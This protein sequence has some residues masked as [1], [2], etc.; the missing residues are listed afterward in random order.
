[1][2]QLVVAVCDRD[3][4]YGRKLSEYWMQ[5]QELSEVRY[6]GQEEELDSCL[7][8]EE[9]DV[10]L[11]SPELLQALSK[12]GIRNPTC[13]AESIHG[14]EAAGPIVICLAEETV[15]EEL[16]AYPCIC[17]YQSADE[18]LRQV[19]H[20]LAGRPMAR[21]QQNYR[22][23]CTIGLCTPWY[24]GNALLAGIAMGRCLSRRG[25]VLYINSRG[26]PGWY[27]EGQ[28]DEVQNLSDIILSLRKAPGDT[29]ALVRSGI[30]TLG[31]ID[32][33]VPVQTARQLEGMECADLVRLLEVVWKELQYDYVVLEL[34]PSL[35]GME[36]VLEQCDRLY[37]FLPP[38]YGEEQLQQRFS[39]EME[40]WKPVLY[41]IPQQLYMECSRMY[42]I[43]PDMAA[44][45]MLG[46]IQ[47]CMGEEDNGHGDKGQ[48]FHGGD[49]EAGA[50]THGCITPDGR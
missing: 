43:Q 9:A 10:C 25:R 17:K 14:V 12:E 31:E 22:K 40:E 15:T 45:E 46:W 44:E 37:G 27:G 24:H 19:Y 38:S 34:D 13:N 33:V 32:Y 16:A 21:K 47:T 50:G 41:R 26:Y 3:S 1:M 49:P 29:G 18:I 2:Q 11:V 4:V 6:I 28:A 23:S 35:A 8:K 39:E 7:E 5:K 20:H 42:E 30:L 48:A 36:S